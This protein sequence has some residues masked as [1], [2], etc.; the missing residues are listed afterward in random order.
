MEKTFLD[1]GCSGFSG[2]FWLLVEFDPAP[3]LVTIEAWLISSHWDPNI[4]PAVA[5]RVCNAA[6]ATKE[7]GWLVLETIASTSSVGV[8]PITH[9]FLEIGLLGEP[10]SFILRRYHLNSRIADS[11]TE[12]YLEVIGQI[13]CLKAKAGCS[14][15][16][17]GAVYSGRPGRSTLE[18]SI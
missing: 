4:L 5:R 8:T 16:A 17:I 6:P 15:R 3:H 9:V 10:Q 1:A 12:G 7:R 14:S 18:Q 13:S 11:D 2:Q